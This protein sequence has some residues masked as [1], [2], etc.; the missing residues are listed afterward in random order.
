MRS[1]IVKNLTLVIILTLCVVFFRE[2]GAIELESK[3]LPGIRMY[4]TRYGSCTP[5]VEAQRDFIFSHYDVST[6]ACPFTGEGHALTNIKLHYRL[7]PY[8]RQTA[9]IG[10]Y[11]LY[12]Y[13]TDQ[14]AS[15]EDLFYHYA[16]DTATDKK[17]AD[18]KAKGTSQVES[19][20]HRVYNYDGTNYTDVTKQAYGTLYNGD[21]RVE[22]DYS[23]DICKNGGSALYIGHISKYK[24]LNVNV[25]TASPNL[26]ISFQYPMLSKMM[27]Q[28]LHVVDTTNGIKNSGKITFAPP[29]NWIKA[30]INGDKLYWIRIKCNTGSGS[31]TLKTTKGVAGVPA[32]SG[33][34][35]LNTNGL[36]TLLGWDDANDTNNDGF[37]DDN[38]FANRLN[39]DASARFKYQA[40]VVLPELNGKYK[41]NLGDQTYKEYAADYAW[42]KVVKEFNMDGLFLD[43]FVLN[44]YTAFDYFKGS[45][46]YLELPDV[47]ESYYQQGADFVKYLKTA[48]GDQ[49]FIMTNGGI[50]MPIIYSEADGV[51]VENYIGRSP[52]FGWEQHG[53]YYFA[54]IGDF[55]KDACQKGRYIV[56]D[57]KIF[58]KKAD[59]AELWG[60]EAIYDLA[61][62]YLLSNSCTMFMHQYDHS[63]PWMDWFDALEYDI[64]APDGGLIIYDGLSDDVDAANLIQNP[65]FESVAIEGA[66]PAP[67]TKF[68]SGNIQYKVSPEN[69]KEGENSL[70]M[71]RKSAGKY[72]AGIA[73]TLNLKPDT[74]YT[75]RAYIKTKDLKGDSYINND[76]ANIYIVGAGSGSVN[77]I[78]SM[79]PPGT[80]DWIA[81]DTVFKTGDI[82][83]KGGIYIKFSSY[84][85]G[86]IW[87]DD[88]RLIEGIQSNNRI[89]ARKFSNGLV[90]LKPPSYYSSPAD[91]T[92]AYKLKLD[93]KYRKLGLD[94]SLSDAM[95]EISLNDLDA[96]IL[97]PEP[98]EDVPPPDKIVEEKSG[99]MIDDA[100]KKYVITPENVQMPPETIIPPETSPTP[101]P[102]APTP[103]PSAEKTDG[104]GC[105][106]I[107]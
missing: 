17:Y 89:F 47:K 20:F 55:L 90:L 43:E 32:I 3:N 101:E 62:Y 81:I 2:A 103:E 69:S 96:A 92:T 79:I 63:F 53:S 93:R 41:M 51:M 100:H 87:I 106:L 104:G 46:P 7:F 94:G 14:N 38:E 72:S 37:V 57:S 74:D 5:Q 75:L 29:A 25:G 18:L 16:K 42:N 67:W 97:V 15:F 22:H 95:D 44:S 56:L 70:Y 76:V 13:A 31:A 105:S 19:R 73:Q 33:E 28:T 50:D 61:T 66:I 107:R 4:A 80:N 8:V 54:R 83:A 23:I 9:P 21:Q 99:D 39:K 52:S 6:T 35:Y 36:F 78:L 30:D 64:G 34:E 88:V 85:T 48:V 26:N 59:N 84:A 58:T 1:Y 12:K 27:W 102:S 49:K 10:Y 86:S 60:K 24:E 11:D 82:T 71:E 45:T 98:N 77:E 68:G 91:E 40:R 65:S